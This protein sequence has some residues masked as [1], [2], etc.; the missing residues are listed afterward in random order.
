[1]KGISGNRFA[2]FMYYLID[3]PMMFFAV[4]WNKLITIIG[5][6][7][8]EVHQDDFVL[9]QNE[10]VS[11]RKKYLRGLR[12]PLYTIAQKSYMMYVSPNSVGKWF[13]K[14][15]CLLGVDKQNFFLRLMFG[16]K[17]SR[18]EVYGYKAMNGWRWTTYLNELNDRD[19]Y[20]ITDPKRLESNVLDVD[21]LRKMYE[22]LK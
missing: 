13:M 9:V 8:N 21:L 16:G 4:I 2:M 1:M 11:K 20:I 12:Y 19:L 18:E 6:F 10:N 22:K 3:I 17:V 7:G 15:I 5:G 14:K